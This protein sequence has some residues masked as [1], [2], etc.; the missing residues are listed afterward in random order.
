MDYVFPSQ[1]YLDGEPWLQ[2]PRTLL[3]DYICPKVIF[4]SG[5]VPGKRICL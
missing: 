5:L 4:Y 2:F 1:K 3:S